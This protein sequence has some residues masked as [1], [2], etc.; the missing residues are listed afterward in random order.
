MG[1]TI[2]GEAGGPPPS[3]LLAGGCGYHTHPAAIVPCVQW[4]THDK[5]QPTVTSWEPGKSWEL[6][7]VT[8]IGP[9]LGEVWL[10]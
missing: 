2:Q 8:D 7:C 10:T 3:P 9:V 1:V 4:Q 5:V 6:T